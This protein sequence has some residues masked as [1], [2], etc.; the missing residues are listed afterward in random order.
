V[1]GLGLALASA[2]LGLGVAGTAAVADPT[3]TTLPPAVETTG[4]VPAEPD[5]VTPTETTEPSAPAEPPPTSSPVTKPAEEPPP[6]EPAEELAEEPAPAQDAPAALSI[7]DVQVTA[8]FDK[9]SYRTGEKMTVTVTVR[10]T[11]ADPVT[12]RVD[13]FP[14]GEDS[15]V[16]DYPNPFDDGNPFTLA[17]GAAKTH[18]I[19]GATGNPNITSAT[20][21]AWVAA[22]TGEA[23][24]FTFAVPIVRTTGH[25]TGTVY[26]D[27]NGNGRYDNGE[28]QAGVTL[29]WNSFWQHG[30]RVTTTTGAAGEFALDLP[31]GKYGLS[32][33]GPD[34]LQVGW[35]PVTVDESGVDDLLVRA[36]GP[37]SGLTA[38]LAFT[39]DSYAKDEAPVVRVTLVNSGDQTLHGI[40]ANCNRGG[41]SN[42]LQ[43]TG[44]GW[45]D[46]ARGGVTLAPRS[47][48]TLDVTEPMPVRAYDYG[49]VFVACDFGYPGVWDENN[50]SDHDRATVPGQRGD[51][52][53]FVGSEGT[54]IAGVRVVL[55]GVDGACPVAETVTDGGGEFAFRQV[56][57]GSYDVYLF[58]PAG[59][60][61]PHDNPTGAQVLGHW[62]AGL[63]LDLER[64][65]PAP[66][67]LPN[68]PTPAPVPA[69]RPAP[70]P[71]PQARTA[72]A[73]AD[74]G[75]SIA[76]PAI[77]GGLAL[78]A[79]TGAVVATRRR[80]P[81]D[82]N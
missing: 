73:L 8:V 42:E 79:G 20:L 10:N 76:A 62:T 58:T 32:G 82:E 7:Q 51:L 26:T 25:V 23:R 77:V 12:T 60:R 47:T 44:E 40:V 61:Y 39:K 45:G 59:W 50:P 31:T 1:A 69:A 65:D 56:P 9:P 13:F 35:Q 17:A 80:K 16:V 54:G 38:E 43:G 4:T 63:Y 74:T 46:L 57:V 36:V 41:F 53:G 67:T 21:H 70:A 14:R 71:A 64:G 15:V 28:G 5:P 24:P 49:D 48:T 52:E 30:P 22:P 72:P 27:R 78:L 37:I 68:C 81:A 66:P 19:T 6:A 55:V 2:V 29:T 75:A 34:G 11:G 18:T 33:T 3:G